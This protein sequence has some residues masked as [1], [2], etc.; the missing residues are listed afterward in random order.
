LGFPTGWSFTTHKETSGAI[1]HA[2]A[3]N[4]LVPLPGIE[5]EEEEEEEA[6]SSTRHQDPI[7]KILVSRSTKRSKKLKEADI[8]LEAHESADSP[9]DVSVLSSLMFLALSV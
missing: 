6:P 5:E 2:P 3:A 1:T 4:F 8:S 9:D 7:K